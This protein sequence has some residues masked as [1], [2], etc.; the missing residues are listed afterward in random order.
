MTVYVN[1][2]HLSN[3]LSIDPFFVPSVFMMMK[4]KLLQK[5]LVALMVLSVYFTFQISYQ[6]HHH[7]ENGE[8]EVAR[9][10]GLDRKDND[11][12]RGKASFQ[13]TPPFEDASTLFKG[14]TQI[15]AFANFNFRSVALIWYERMTKLG[16]RTHTI[17]ATDERM[18]DFLRTNTSF[19][20]EISIHQELPSLPQ[21]PEQS[22]TRKNKVQQNQKEK[23]D[24][25]KLLM[26]VRWKV[27]QEKLD[28]GI[29]VLLTDVDNIFN[30][31]IDMDTE[32]ANSDPTIDVY[33]AYATKYPLRIYKKRGFVV[34]SGMSWW[35]SI[36]TSKSSSWSISATQSKTTISQ[37]I[38]TQCGI[39]CDDQVVL[40]TLLT[41]PK[42]GMD[43]IWTKDAIDSRITNNTYTSTT[44]DEKEDMNRIL[45]IPTIGITGISNTTNQK[46]KIWDRTFAYRGPII[47]SQCPHPPGVNWVSM[48]TIITT[49]SRATAWE[50]KI[51]SFQDWDT[52]CG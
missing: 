13:N 31:Y 52:I 1:S 35:R 45:G 40:N 25:L 12:L 36:T 24:I 30:R 28:Q 2:L 51:Q 5:V 6:W 29:H 8:D 42:L 44:P 32:F 48:P 23:H 21:D 7:M 3:T 47:A 34:C 22:E 37:I 9:K 4:W 38:H 19:R 43:W 39:M 26:A 46:I 33:M 10:Q 18:V 14:Q 49:K 17:I 41:G 27:L 20:Y 11:T 50:S 16:Y 15:I